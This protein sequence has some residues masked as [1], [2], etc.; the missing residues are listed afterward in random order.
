MEAFSKVQT[1]I[2]YPYSALAFEDRS[3]MP[4]RQ[5]KKA[6]RMPVNKGDSHPSCGRIRTESLMAQSSRSYG[7]SSGVF[8]V[9]SSL[10][11][12]LV[13]RFSSWRIGHRHFRRLA[14]M[15]GRLRRGHGVR[16]RVIT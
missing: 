1:D 7:F 5:V 11:V 14:L 8:R 15:C 6:S 9:A 4:P 16:S 2:N 10:I 13:A 12:I 3:S